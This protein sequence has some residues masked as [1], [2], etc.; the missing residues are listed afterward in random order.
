MFGDYMKKKKIIV[1]LLVMV[2]GVVALSLVSFL[3]LSL[4]GIVY[5]DDGVKFNVELFQSFT[6]SWY[7]WL[8]IIALQSILTMLLSAIPGVSMAFILL[9]SALYPN[10]IEAFLISFASVLVTSVCMHILGRSGGYKLCVKML[11]AEDCEKAMEL[12]RTKG[13]VYFPLMM[14]FPLF[15]DDALVMVSGVIKMRLKW[16][17]PSIVIGRGI[18]VATIVFGLSIIPFDTFDGVYDWI[19]FITVCVFWLLMVFKLAHKLSVWMENKK[20]LK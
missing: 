3:L 18:G 7:G 13:T 4:F 14:M 17:L 10:P 6:S 1:T 16:F 15:P 2:C 8:V 5:Y 12:L 19:V 11:G 20:S 9:C